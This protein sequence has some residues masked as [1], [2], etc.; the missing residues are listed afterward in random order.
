M[1]HVP[2]LRQSLGGQV[3]VLLPALLIVALAM[4]HLTIAVVKKERQEVRQQVA[5]D[6]A[7]RAAAAGQGDRIARAMFVN[8]AVVA[9]YADMAESA[10]DGAVDASQPS[11]SGL[12]RAVRLAK[13][14]T[15]LR[16]ID[17]A[18][19]APAGAP[20]VAGQGEFQTE[21]WSVP[22]QA[23]RGAI[24]VGRVT[25]ASAD[26]PSVAVAVAQ[27]VPLSPVDGSVVAPNASEA[28]AAGFQPIF[29]YAA[30][31]IPVDEAIRGAI[32]PE[33]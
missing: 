9:G 11:V 13:Y 29:T 6:A 20:L 31:L 17:D 4:L 18:G 25:S 15:E 23:A 2:R 1:R 27:M 8:D 24:A 28:Y 19:L 7:A 32:V 26:S 16:A 30:R 10:L 12:E 14:A 3:L 5:A 21:I 22:A 33:Q